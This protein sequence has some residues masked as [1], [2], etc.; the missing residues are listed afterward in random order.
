MIKINIKRFSGG[1]F[2]YKYLTLDDY[3]SGCMEDEEL[4]ELIDDLVVVLKD[5]E[6]WKSCD[7]SE[8]E[9]RDT[10]N[11]FKNKWLKNKETT[12]K[13]KLNA[14]KRHLEDGIKIIGEE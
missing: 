2:D 8:E 4:N 12:S 5:L 1:S 7:K 14:I 13:I 11:K 3:Y 6:W 9:Y 10:V